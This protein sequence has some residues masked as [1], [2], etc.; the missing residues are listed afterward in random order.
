[1]DLSSREIV[2]NLSKVSVRL[3]SVYWESNPLNL[4][5]LVLGNQTLSR[6]KHPNL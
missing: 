3:H 6:T 2:K 5:D 1:M 4:F